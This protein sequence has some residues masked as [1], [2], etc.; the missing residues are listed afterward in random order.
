MNAFSDFVV[1]VRSFED[2]IELEV[3]W[4]V[5]EAAQGGRL[6]YGC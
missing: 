5:V 4:Q 6:I 1:S 2:V 3:G